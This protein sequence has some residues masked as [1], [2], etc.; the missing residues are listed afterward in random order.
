MYSIKIIYSHQRQQSNPVLQQQIFYDLSN[1]FLFSSNAKKRKGRDISKY[2][3]FPQQLHH[4]IGFVVLCLFHYLKQQ[5]ILFAISASATMENSLR[6]IYFVPQDTCR[7]QQVEIFRIQKCLTEESYTEGKIIV[8]R[9]I[10]RLGNT[11]KRN[12]RYYSIY[13][14]LAELLQKEQQVAFKIG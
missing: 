3:L 4:Q 14:Y 5:I 1:S 11:L 2:I 13:K 7:K 9:V 8:R 10:R 12:K 6:R